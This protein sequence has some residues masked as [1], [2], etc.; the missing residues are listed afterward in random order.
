MGKA[1]SLSKRPDQRI[2][3]EKD[4]KNKTL[5]KLKWLEIRRTKVI[6][7]IVNGVDLLEKVRKSKV[8]D[9]KVV[10]TVEEMKRA[11][12]KILRDEE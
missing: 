1:N 9:D 2:R 5:V 11:G 10:K 7:I 4:N 3:V 6:E 8:K 12:V